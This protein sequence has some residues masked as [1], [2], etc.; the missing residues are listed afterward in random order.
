MSKTNTPTYKHNFQEPL[1][2]EKTLVYPGENVEVK[3]PV[4][5]MPSDT[6]LYMHA[7]VYRSF[8]PGPTVLIL[9]GVHG[10]EINGIEI[11]SQLNL[12][13]HFYNLKMG[14]VI[15]IPLVNLFG[16]NNFSRDLPDGKDV[17]RSFPGTTTGSLASRVASS[18]TKKFLPYCEYAIDLHTGG[19][20]RYNYP[21]IRYASKIIGT[22]ELAE[23]FQCPFIIDQVMIPNSFRK[24]AAE[25]NVKT[26]VY[27]AGESIRLDGLAIEYGKNGILNI[28]NHLNMLNPI[29]SI[30][31]PRPNTV[32][33]NK[34]YWQRSNK[35]GIFI[36]SKCAGQFVNKGEILGVLKDPYGYNK[37]D[38]ICRYSGY[39]IGHNNASVVNQ[40]DALFH[41]GIEYEKNSF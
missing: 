1:E 22:K 36:W 37:S 2:F 40:G 38:V 39:I 23:A 29:N 5:K 24:T 11:A 16:F 34:T 3:I 41:I 32:K 33:I 13:Q 31:Q 18:I 19:A 28:L 10:D 17:N 15:V 27:E 35:S 12:E 20:S 26:I 21:Q 9:A 6:R 7:F 25:H 4:A 14:N 30:N 8:N